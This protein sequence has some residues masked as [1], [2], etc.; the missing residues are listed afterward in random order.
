MA[1]VWLAWCL[2][3]SPRPRCAVRAGPPDPP[4][5]FRSTATPEQQDARFPGSEVRRRALESAL[6]DSHGDDA[7]DFL[8]DPAFKGSSALRTYNSFVYPRTTGAV[9]AATKPG[10]AYVIA[11]QIAFHVRELRASRAAW[12]VNHDAALASTAGLVTHPLTLVLDNLRSAE[13][14]GNILRLAD[15][16]RIARVVTTGITPRPP[17]ARLLKTAMGTAEVVAQEHVPSALVAVR[18]LQGSGA[19]VCAC[20]TVTG[21]PSLFDEADSRLAEA[22]EPP[23][24]L[25]FGNE[26]AGVDARVLAEVDAVVRLPTFGAKNSLNVAC[27]VSIAVY[28]VLRRWE[29]L[30]PER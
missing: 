17:Q 5:Q 28:E 6:V 14:C 30:T 18:A 16:A 1:A 13:N 2:V 27:A 8:S 23:L 12:L 20:E 26:V 25:V 24:A 15:C 10:R 7:L 9:A 11:D 21:A 19:R 29:A 4:R 22:L 3:G